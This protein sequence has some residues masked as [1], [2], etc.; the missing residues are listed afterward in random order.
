MRSDADGLYQTGGL[1]SCVLCLTKFVVI[2]GKVIVP[3]WVAEH[4]AKQSEAESLTSLRE[5]FR[6]ES[7]PP[8]L[9]ERDLKWTR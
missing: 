1:C 5:K 2:E 4:N 7:A 9:V 6:K 8:A 3:S